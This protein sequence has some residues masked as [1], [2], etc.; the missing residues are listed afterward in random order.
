MEKTNTW[1][2]EDHKRNDARVYLEIIVTNAVLGEVQEIKGKNSAVYVISEE[3]FKQIKS[4][5][6]NK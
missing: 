2:L 5:L 6:I 4:N 1:I 3:Q